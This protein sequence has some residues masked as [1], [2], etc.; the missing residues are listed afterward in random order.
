MPRGKPNPTINPW[1]TVWKKPPK[2][3]NRKTERDGVTYDSKGEADR[4]A[5]L[6]VLEMAGRISGLTKQ[7]RIPLLVGDKKVCTYVADFKYEQDGK[8]VIEDFKGFETDTFK[9]KWKLLQ[10]LHP[11]WEFKITRR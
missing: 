9:L 2:Y 4:A 3:G 7:F 10:A 1:A 11:E 8:V 6:E 5:V